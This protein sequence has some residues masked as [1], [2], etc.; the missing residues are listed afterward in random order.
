MLSNLLNLLICLRTECVQ[1]T[2]SAIICLVNVLLLSS[3]AVGI[4]AG[5]T[6]TVDEV[7]IGEAKRGCLE[8]ALL[9]VRFHQLI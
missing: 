3:F 4:R 6:L 7:V 1:E 8:V 9:T 5:V 2:I